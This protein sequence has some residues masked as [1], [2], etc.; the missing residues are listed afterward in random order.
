[1][2]QKKQPSHRYRQQTG[3]WEGMG[4]LVLFQQIEKKN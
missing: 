2:K 3:G 4:E 1:M